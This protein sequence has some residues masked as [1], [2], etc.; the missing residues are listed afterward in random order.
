MGEMK[1]VSWE[2]RMVDKGILKIQDGWQLWNVILGDIKKN[3]ESGIYGNLNEKISNSETIEV[4]DIS[5]VKIGNA[6]IITV[7]NDNEK[8]YYDIKIL[9]I[10]KNSATKNFLIEIVDKE[11]LDKTGGIIKGM[12]GSPIIQNGKIIGAV[13]HAI[14]DKPNKGYGISIIKMLEGE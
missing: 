13:T 3:I 5:E 1:R 14:V 2:Y 8:K 4:A 12:S 11:L 10:D 9:S 7:L 6:E